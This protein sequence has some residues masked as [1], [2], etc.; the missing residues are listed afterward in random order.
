MKYELDHD[1]YVLVLN[2]FI[3]VCTGLYRVLLESREETY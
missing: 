3:P 1:V 2:K